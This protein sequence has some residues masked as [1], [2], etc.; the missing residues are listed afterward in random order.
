MLIRKQGGLQVHSPRNMIFSGG[1]E[2]HI[3]KIG[4]DRFLMDISKNGNSCATVE[5][6]AHLFEGVVDLFK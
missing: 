5:F 4:K 3:S 6:P 2:A 1:R